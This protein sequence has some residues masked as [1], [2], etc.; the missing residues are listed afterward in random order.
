VKRADAER[1]KRNAKD[2]ERLRWFIN[3]LF[4]VSLE[5]RVGTQHFAYTTT[6]LPPG[7]ERVR[8]VLAAIDAGMAAE[9]PK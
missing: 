6:E 3:S 5:I 1:A 4:N 8:A 2:A 7:S 9:A